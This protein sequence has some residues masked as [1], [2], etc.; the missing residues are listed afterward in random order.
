[1]VA[2]D[3]LPVGPL[4]AGLQFWLQVL[5][6]VSPYQPIH[7]RRRFAFERKERFPKHIGAEMVEERGELFL[8]LLACGFP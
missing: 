3:T 7:A 5:R 6:I 8:L 1:M 4:H 2:P